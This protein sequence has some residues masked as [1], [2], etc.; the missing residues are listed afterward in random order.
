METILFEKGLVTFTLDIVVR[1]VKQ[2]THFTSFNSFYSRNPIF[3][4]KE[5][6]KETKPG[7]RHGKPKNT[8]DKGRHKA[9]T[10][11]QKGC[12]IQISVI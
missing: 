10:L 11:K 12:T 2:K 6:G 9:P 4:N 1:V 8:A 3:M 7:E 5:R